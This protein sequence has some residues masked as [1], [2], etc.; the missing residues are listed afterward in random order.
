MMFNPLD[1]IYLDN[2]QREPMTPYDVMSEKDVTKIEKVWLDGLKSE[3]EPS[4]RSA[5][6]TCLANWANECHKRKSRFPRCR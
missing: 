4:L 6:D 1:T 2:A 5:M 3:E